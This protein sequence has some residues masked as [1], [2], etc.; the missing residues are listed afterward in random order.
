MSLQNGFY[1]LRD[2]VANTQFYLAKQVFQR[3]WVC[4]QMCQ[5]LKFYPI[6][7]G[8]TS[9]TH[10]RRARGN[11]TALKYIAP[12]SGITTTTDP[13]IVHLRTH[14]RFAVEQIAV[15]GTLRDNYRNA[16]YNMVNG[17]PDPMLAKMMQKI[18]DWGQSAWG[19]SIYGRYLDTAT[20]STIGGIPS[21]FISGA[22]DPGVYNDETR[23]DGY[24][25][26]K[27]A[28]NKASYKAPGDSDYGPE[29]VVNSGDLVTLYSGNIDTYITFTVGTIP[30]SDGES[31]IAFSSTSKMPDGLINL[32]E[33]EQKITLPGPQNF[34]FRMI[35]ELLN[36]LHPVYRDNPG[37]A[38]VMHTETF[39]AAY[40][41]SQQSGGAIIKEMQFGEVFK[42]IVD[43][44]LKNIGLTTVHMY[45]GHPIL[46]CDQIPRKSIGGKPCLSMFAVCLDPMAVVGDG[47]DFGGFIGVVNG[48][49]GGMVWDRFGFGWKL[50]PIGKAQNADLDLG[51]IT[52]A[53]AW[54]LGDSG[55]ASMIEGLY[56]PFV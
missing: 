42:D 7:N 56:D 54:S 17:M 47:L 2:A 10:A 24:L 31:A 25:K 46:K 49:P 4:N 13:H 30:G 53:H 40:N 20:L 21:T 52:L 27:A 18:I 39:E 55:A 36:R 19:S 26:F 50:E 44:M 37:T 33:K 51:R 14:L 32:I 23:G 43:P 1:T 15:P 8:E 3:A 6:L 45:R 9:I 12:G 41:L 38:I 34:E 11:A 35:G 28:T 48:P 16:P 22:I 29:V 5:F